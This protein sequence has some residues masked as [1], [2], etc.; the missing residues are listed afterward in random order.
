MDDS[1]VAYKILY[2]ERGYLRLEVPSIRKFS[3]TFLFTNFKKSPPFP[4][5]AGI[6][7][8]HVNPFK[9]SIVIIYE[10]EDIDIMGYIKNMATDPDIKKIIKG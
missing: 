3:W 1:A 6:K 10:P 8:L 5:P 4:I 7:D 2:H 9:G